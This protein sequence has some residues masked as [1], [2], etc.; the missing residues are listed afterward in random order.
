[1]RI[2][3]LT[4]LF[5]ALSGCGGEGADFERVRLAGEVMY[6]EPASS[7]DPALVFTRDILMLDE[8]LYILDGKL[9]HVVIFDPQ[10]RSILNTF[11]GVGEG[12][13]ELGRFPYALVSDGERIGVAHLFTVSWFTPE[14]EYLESESLPPLDLSTPSL[15]WS[16][17]GWLSNA[18]F[19]GPG[20]PCATYISSTGDSVGYG[21][22]VAPGR[23]DEFGLAAMELNAVHVGRFRN[24]NVIAGHVQENRITIFAPDGASIAEDAWLQA[25]ERPERGPTGQLRGYPGFTL[26]LKMGS[27]GFAYLLDGSLR[28]VRR[29]DR[30]GSLLAEFEFDL[31]VIRVLWTEPGIALAIDGTDR[32]IRFRVG[33]GNTRPSSVSAVREGDSSVDSSPLPGRLVERIGDLATYLR[34]Q[35]LVREEGISPGN[36]R[37]GRPTA[38]GGT[39][40]LYLGYPDGPGLLLSPAESGVD[41]EWAGFRVDGRTGAHPRG[42]LRSRIVM[43]GDDPVI[44][45]PGQGL[46]PLRE[47][48]SGHL[49]PEGT[50]P[51]D[52]TW[53]GEERWLVH[54]TLSKKQDPLSVIDLATGTSMPVG[55][56]GT[57]RPMGLTFKPAWNWWWMRRLDGDRVIIFDESS[58]RIATWSREGISGWHSLTES[59]LRTVDERKRGLTLD[60]EVAAL[61][62][63]EGRGILILSNDPAAEEPSNRLTLVSFEGTILRRWD[64]PI[65]LTVT[66]MTLTAWGDLYLFTRRALL[67]WMGWKEATAVH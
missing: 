58:L 57:H 22:A 18:P 53:L 54:D 35:S 10:G 42:S 12:P 29:Y 11:G 31:P 48:H 13:G 24:G 52:A 55:G 15:Q 56:A 20:S 51:S 44:F 41:T 43:A 46:L 2:G 37:S 49:W 61:C 5:L 9:A 36:M 3:L 4:A 26:S 17:G 50:W 59:G 1:M 19:R 62:V 7:T 21:R 65:Q 8:R 40:R 23:S 6:Q 25:P 28:R 27:D 30:T 34:D 60:R 16:A 33:E 14:G 39:T 47:E 45:D 67:E 32:V 66:G 64:L 63:L 38:V